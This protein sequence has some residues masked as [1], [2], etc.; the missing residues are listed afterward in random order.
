MEIANLLY[1][2]FGFDT[3]AESATFVDFI[4]TTCKVMIGVYITVFIIRSVFLLL[5]VPE[6]GLL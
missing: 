1:T 6:R 3:L 4:S 2:F 5:T